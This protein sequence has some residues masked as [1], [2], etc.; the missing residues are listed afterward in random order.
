MP[1]PGGSWSTMAAFPDVLTEQNL[2]ELRAALHGVETSSDERR[3]SERIEYPVI[4][5][6][7]PCSPGQPVRKWGF[8]RV[9]CRDISR[10]GI[11]FFW[12]RK[13]DFDAVLVVLGPRPNALFLTARV[14]WSKPAEGSESVF[15]L[16]CQFLEKVDPAIL[17]GVRPPSPSSASDP[18]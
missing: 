14:A 5:V 7:A 8:F 17:D 4:Q 1:P 2:S 15:L 12:P 6:A 10:G 11:C 9:R 13:P 18:D 16:G 3:G